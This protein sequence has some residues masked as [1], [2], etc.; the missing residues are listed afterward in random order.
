[1][2]ETIVLYHGTPN[3]ESKIVRGSIICRNLHDGKGEGECLKDYWGHIDKIAS[4]VKTYYKR[5]GI[6]KTF[7]NN[8]L[9]AMEALKRIDPLYMLAHKDEN[10]GYSRDPYEEIQSLFGLTVSDLVSCW[11]AIRMNHV[12]F[13]GTIEIPKD[14]VETKGRKE[15]E[16][17]T[18]AVLELAIPRKD[19]KNYLEAY[20]IVWW[21][22]PITEENLLVVYLKNGHERASVE[23]LLRTHQFN[24]TKIESFPE[25]S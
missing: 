19:V 13:F 24:H 3:L 2:G 6:E 8:E 21:S 11:G 4:A 20:P 23:D 14:Y 7:S 22:V 10:P 12:Y 15:I 5:E 9:Y 1:M 17:Q 25:F 16:V 18:Q